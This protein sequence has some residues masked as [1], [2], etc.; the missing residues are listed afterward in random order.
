MKKRKL[1]SFVLPTL[2]FLV[3][4]GIFACIILLGSN[5]E[6]ESTDYDY[7]MEILEEVSNPVIKEE[8]VSTKVIKE[9]IEEDSSVITIHFYDRL[10]DKDK[11][12]ASLIYYEN[13]YIPS[14][15]VIYTSDQ[16]FNV[17]AVFDGK[18]VDIK[19]DEFMGKYIICE[20]SNTLK[21]YYYGL[22]NIEVA[23]GD[24]L[25]TGTILGTSKVNKILND[26]YTFLF[27]V[28]HNNKLI[29][30]ETIYNTKITDYE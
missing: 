15:G 11:Q 5:M 14:T 18:I 4:T 13:T 19:E 22:D 7:G 9:P 28:Y 29:N 24:D 10:D 2:Y 27:E 6:L 17:L 20:H 8:V 23:I 1:K 21:T 25:T 12:I 26:K 16:E 30:P 3:I